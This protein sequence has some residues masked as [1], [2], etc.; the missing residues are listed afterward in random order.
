MK[1]FWQAKAQKLGFANIPQEKRRHI[2]WNVASISNFPFQVYFPF[3]LLL[4]IT[5]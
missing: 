5:Y 3:F 1:V 4:V 2:A